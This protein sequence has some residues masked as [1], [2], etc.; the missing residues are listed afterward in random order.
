MPE[1]PPIT[2]FFNNVP[3][4]PAPLEKQPKIYIGTKTQRKSNNNKQIA[5]KNK[6]INIYFILIF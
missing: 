3:V 2:H 6:V 4:M 1:I 5:S